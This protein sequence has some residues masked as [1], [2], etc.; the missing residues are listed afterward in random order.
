MQR[1][2]HGKLEGE[3]WEVENGYQKDSD[4]S[5]KIALI[6]IERSITAWAKLYELLPL[7]EDVAL[8]SLALLQQLQQKAKEEF[9]D[10]MQFKR[11]GFDD[12]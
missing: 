1:A 3:D 9:P 11:P 6:A 2:L 4:G 12:K 5:T 7:S 8:E 10:A